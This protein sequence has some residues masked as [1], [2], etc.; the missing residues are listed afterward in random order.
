[1]RFA[2]YLGR[3][4]LQ[5][6]KAARSAEPKSSGLLGATVNFEGPVEYVEYQIQQ[7]ATEKPDCFVVSGCDEVSAREELRELIK[8]NEKVRA[9]L[10]RSVELRK[11]ILGMLSTLKSFLM[12]STH[13]PMLLAEDGPRQLQVDYGYADHGRGEDGTWI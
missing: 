9:I 12:P 6:L 2:G 3:I 5:V 13:P 7:I 11:C 4:N 10:S 1:M 8:R